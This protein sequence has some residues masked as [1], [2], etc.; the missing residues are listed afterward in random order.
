M[1]PGFDRPDHSGI[2]RQ[3]TRKCMFCHNAY[4]QVPI[5]SDQGLAQAFPAALPSG[6]GCQRCHGP[7]G[8][9]VELALRGETSS[10]SVAAAIV[11]PA[12]LTPERRNDVC[13]QCHLQP[14]VV[15]PLQRRFG[16]GD[17]S[18]RPGEPLAEYLPQLDVVEEGLAREDRFEINHHPYRLEQSR[19][20]VASGGALSCLTCH[21]PHR[22][23]AEEDRAAH[24]RER[25][26]S[27]H[28]DDALEP[29]HVANAELE[30]GGWE[31]A[32]CTA[33]HM[34]PRRPSDVVAVVMTD[35][36]IQG[37]GGGAAWLETRPEREP[38]VILDLRFLHP[39][40]TPPGAEG[41]LHRVS[42]AVAM[43][44]D[45]GAVEHLAGIVER[46]RPPHPGAYRQL[47]EGLLANQRE[48]QALHFLEQASTL[49]PGDSDLRELRALALAR[50]GEVAAA[51]LILER[52][53]EA[54]GARP[55]AHYNL[56]LLLVAMDR[57]VAAIEQLRSAVEL[58]PNFAAAW[59][60]LGNVYRR[61]ERTELAEEAYR[62][63]L[64]AEP[65]FPEAQLAVGELL[66]ERG[67]AAEALDLL[68]LA[69]RTAG[70][71]TAG[72]RTA[73]ARTAAKREQLVALQRRAAAALAGD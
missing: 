11:N 26:L 21:D 68:E 31:A 50:S 14:A 12:R 40:Q 73:G 52:L 44:A 34:P 39:E 10:G 7:G 16:R 69:A 25:C 57:E 18:Y 17:Y 24:Y 49:A 32:D 30:G 46:L 63:A 67:A 28:G 53:V 62:R 15:L 59:Q 72:A 66:L 45:L 33:C 60:S 55:E 27:C 70:A 56:G 29:I 19:C 13:Y 1:A 8:R 6:I 4:P 43:G 47:V 71:R 36:R 54:G 42:S 9:H 23:V 48:S 65:S 41:E 5:A 38:G 3:V 64:I 58:R 51:V 35:H 61:L 20:F 37:R 22:R 2:N